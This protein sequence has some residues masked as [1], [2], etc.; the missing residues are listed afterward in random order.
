[1]LS[2]VRKSD[3]K[4]SRFRL[5]YEY[6]AKF[7]KTW[8]KVFLC[9]KFNE[10]WYKAFLWKGDSILHDYSDVNNMNSKIKFDE[11]H[12]PIWS[13]NYEI[14]QDFLLV[15]LPLFKLKGNQLDFVLM[16]F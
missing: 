8:Y 12:D 1:M 5:L 7:N 11:N 6:C 13:I 14:L 3:C 4:I 9:A 15:K 2:V 16:H 10:T